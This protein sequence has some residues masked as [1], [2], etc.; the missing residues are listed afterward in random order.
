[1][2]TE[3][4]TFSPTIPVSVGG[5]A[6]QVVDVALSM[7]TVPTNCARTGDGLA[8]I[9]RSVASISRAEERDIAVC[10]KTYTIIFV[11]P[12]TIEGI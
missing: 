10:L 3:T 7:Q 11:F 2:F 12:V 9:A 1:M 8:V 6:G 5:D 4:V